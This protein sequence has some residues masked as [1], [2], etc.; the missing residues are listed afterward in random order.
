MA[1]RSPRAT[2]G[3]AQAL[4]AA[5]L[6]GI[7]TPIAK[8]L[9]EGASPQVLAGLLY[10]GSGIGLGAIWLVQRA[11]GRRSE[12]PLVQRDLRWLAGAVLFGGMLAPLALM[13]G[14]SR[15][16]ASASA[17]LLNLEG[18][19]TALIAWVVFA[20][21]VDRRIALGMLAIVVGGALLSWQGRLEWGG[22]I[23]PLLVVC[24]CLGWAVD[25]NLTQKVSASDPIQI[26]AI[27]GLVAGTVNLAI[28]L[29]LH[30]ALP[31]GPRVAGAMALGFFSYGVSLVLFVLAMRSLGT[32]RTGA[33]FSLAPFVG[34]AG[35]LLL[36]HD[37]VTPLFFA[38]AT[39]MAFGLW[40]HLTER[41]E[42]FHSHEPLTHTHRHEHDEH[43]QHEHDA[44]DP[45]GEPHTHEHTHARFAHSHAHTPDIHHRHGH[46]EPPST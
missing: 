34:A 37:R 18:V 31:S 32:A 13:T 19:F 22:A 30:G 21:N 26:A 12:A 1:D 42:H 28:G 23:G 11:R 41:H 39:L 35:G 16:P 29:T 43:H 25:N 46:G 9:L 2:A 44:G 33:Y 6:F 20:E 8:G 15:T 45:Q 10:L 14:L 3:I 17:L 4:I 24:A 27:K 40:L 5:A 38:A 7:S 36:W